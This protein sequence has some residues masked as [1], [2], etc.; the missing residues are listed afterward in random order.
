MNPQAKAVA[1]EIRLLETFEVDVTDIDESYAARRREILVAVNPRLDDIAE[2]IA[3]LEAK[4][5]ELIEPYAEVLEQVEAEFRAEADARYE[6][7]REKLKALPELREQLGELLATDYKATGEKTYP[8]REFGLQLRQTRTIV[9]A[10]HERAF[11]SLQRELKPERLHHYLSI[12]KDGLGFVEN[13]VA[14][15]KGDEEQVHKDL[16]TDFP[17]FTLTVKNTPVFI[18]G[19]PLLEEESAEA[20][21][22]GHVN[23]QTDTREREGTG[24]A[25]LASAPPI[26]GFDGCEDPAIGYDPLWEHPVCERCT[27]DRTK[28]QPLSEWQS[29]KVA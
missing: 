3:M 1:E 26:C 18:A 15:K 13:A 23:A 2:R 25:A 5:L 29:G 7:H 21:E 22:D 4:R 24:A 16:A 12:N 19:D 27:T 10:D 17:G 20:Q 6:A 9:I 8:G 14:A 28:L 11:A